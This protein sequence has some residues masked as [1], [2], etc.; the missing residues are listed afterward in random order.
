MSCFTIGGPGKEHGT[1]KSPPTRRVQ[2]RL[3]GN[4]IYPTTSQNPSRWHPSWLNKACTTRKDSE[5]E[6]LAKDNP[7]T[8][9]ITIKP[10]TLPSSRAVL[11]GSLTLLLS[12]RVPFPDKIFCFISICVSS[13][14]SFPMLDMSPVSGPGRGL[15][16]TD[17]WA[18]RLG[19]S[20]DVDDSPLTIFGKPQS[21]ISKPHLVCKQ[22]ELGVGWMWSWFSSWTHRSS[23]H[24][25]KKIFLYENLL[26]CSVSRRSSEK[27]THTFLE[28]TEFNLFNWIQF[29]IL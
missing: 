1:N 20:M 14:N 23:N 8:N 12:T 22:K 10:E 29:T 3:K 27:E 26:T 15:P 24:L 13:D 16:A 5:S 6:W 21:K 19:D 2:Q 4:T 18:P 25:L 9:P 7:E 11:L 28:K 17:S